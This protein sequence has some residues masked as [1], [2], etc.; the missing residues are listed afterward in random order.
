[1]DV[2]HATPEYIKFNKLKSDKNSSD[3]STDR[4]NEITH[5]IMNSKS[6]DFNTAISWLKDTHSKNANIKNKNE[7]LNTSLFRSDFQRLKSVDVNPGNNKIYGTVSSMVVNNNGDLNHS[8]IYLL[9]VD[10]I[11]TD[12]HNRQLIKYRE[13]KTTIANL[14]AKKPVFIKRELIR[15]P[16]VNEVCS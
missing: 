7:C 10:S 11:T 2:V 15:N 14:F 4:L 3:S 1:M 16:P 12:T 6:R 8:T 9:M 5:L 13:L